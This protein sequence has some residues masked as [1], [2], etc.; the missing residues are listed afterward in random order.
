VIRAKVPGPDKPEAGTSFLRKTANSAKN[1]KKR[2]VDL[3]F[4]DKLS[5]ACSA[6][7]YPERF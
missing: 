5:L 3:I 1:G 4:K 7:L 2:V 6:V